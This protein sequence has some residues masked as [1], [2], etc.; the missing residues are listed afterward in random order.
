LFTTVA[1]ETG[2][3]PYG[4]TSSRNALTAAPPTSLKRA[5]F[6]KKSG[7]LILNVEVIWTTDFWVMFPFHVSPSQS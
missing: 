6:D 2:I 7:D 1:R 4:W 3:C 5:E